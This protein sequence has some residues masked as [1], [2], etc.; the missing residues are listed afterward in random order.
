MSIPIKS[1]LPVKH[2]L[3]Q[4]ATAVIDCDDELNHQAVTD[5]SQMFKKVPNT[6]VSQNDVNN[7]AI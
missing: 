4:E 6:G 5:R 7:I 2:A 1:M 3:S